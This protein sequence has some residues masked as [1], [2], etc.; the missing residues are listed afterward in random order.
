MNDVDHH[1]GKLPGATDNIEVR[2]LLQLRSQGGA[3][4]RTHYTRL[5]W[6]ERR[7]ERWEREKIRVAS[8]VRMGNVGNILK[9]RMGGAD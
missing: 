4:L 3:G 8:L 1:K 7:K 9:K 6:K 5:I 2:S